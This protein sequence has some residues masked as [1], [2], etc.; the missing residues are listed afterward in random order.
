[1]EGIVADPSLTVYHSWI[2]ENRLE[3]TFFCIRATEVAEKRPTRKVATPRAACKFQ[4]DFIARIA[5]D[6]HFHL[7]LNH[8]GNICALVKDAAGRF[9]WVS[10]N[11]ARR[12]GFNEPMEM[13]GLDDAAVSPMRLVKMYRRD[14]LEV[15]RSGQPLLGRIELVFNERGMLD[16]SV[17]NKLPLR[18][19]TGKVIGLILTIQQYSGVRQ[20]PVFGGELSA[21]VEYIFAHLGE[22]LQVKQLAAIAGVSCRQIERR[23]HS[24]TGMSP[25]DFIIRARLDEAC[26]RLRDGGDSIGR[27][28]LDLGFYDQS[29]FTRLFRRHLGTTPSEFR[30]T[31]RRDA[32]RGT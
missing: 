17:T 25:T 8:L 29:A 20:L 28:A 15:M 18:D 11:L 22:S 27:I 14:D 9:V 1:M 12:F 7:A 2:R 31:R 4:G 26:R 32:A 19:A 24:A 13:V 10:D 6:S 5:P 30:Q 21:V 3:T 16:W 23:F